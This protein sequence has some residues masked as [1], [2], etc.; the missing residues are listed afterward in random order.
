MEMFDFRSCTPSTFL[1]LSQQKIV[2]TSFQSIATPCSSYIK[3][4]TILCSLCLNNESS[5]SLEANSSTK[6]RDDESAASKTSMSSSTATT[7]SQRRSRIKPTVASVARSRPNAATKNKTSADVGKNELDGKSKEEI[8]PV[9]QSQLGD[10][11]DPL[12]RRLIFDGEDADGTSTPSSQ[13]G[14][15]AVT[16]TRNPAEISASLTNIEQRTQPVVQETVVKPSQIQ[17]RNT[18][19]DTAVLQPSDGGT[20]PSLLRRKRVL[21]NLGSAARRRRSSVSKENVEKNPDFHEVRQEEINSAHR[22]E[23]LIS[24]SEEIMD[25]FLFQ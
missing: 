16:S 12:S 13:E 21:P 10:K 25:I 3:F 7:G 8:T 4:K 15:Q 23:G 14:N 6:Q 22:D 11:E 1:P 17:N 2:A 5:E 24:V 18:N 9:S 20:T 19:S